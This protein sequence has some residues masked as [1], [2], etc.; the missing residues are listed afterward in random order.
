V[1]TTDMWH[2][3]QEFCSFVHELL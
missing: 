2:L 1:L 3:L